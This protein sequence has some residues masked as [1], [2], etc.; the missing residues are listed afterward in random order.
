MEAFLLNHVLFSPQDDII[1]IC[2]DNVF[3]TIFTQDTPTSQKALRRL[4]SA[5]IGRPVRILAVTANEPPVSGLTDRQIRYD[6]RVR[7]NDG[8]QANIEMTLSPSGFE[9]LRLEY[10]AARLHTTQDIKGSQ[11]SFADL[12]SAYQIAI[13]G[14]KRLFKDEALVH[15]FS[16]YDPDLGLS[17]GGRTRII[18]VELEK[19]EGLL[20]RSLKDMSPAEWWILFFRYITDP[21]KRELMNEL[22]GYEEGI[23]MAGETLLRISR[24][25]AERARLESEYKYQLDHQSEMVTARREG[26]RIGRRLGLKKGKRLGQK[27][28]QQKIEARLRAMGLS[29]EQIAE[30]T[31]L[32]P[33]KSGD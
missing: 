21:E 7:F 25:E 4:L 28:E 19:A 5:F 29:P 16:Y 11:K 6:I 22:A 15:R 10:Y 17:L 13:V 33:E 18:V 20:G 26:E 2:W 8:E 9:P 31:G 24:D 1:D 14:N 30:A 23:G 32:S 12:R 3:K 27:R